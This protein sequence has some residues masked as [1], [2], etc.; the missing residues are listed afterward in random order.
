MNT[1]AEQFDMNRFIA[2]GFVLIALFAFLYYQYSGIFKHI[3][4]LETAFETA[5]TYLAIGVV[6]SAVAIYV[7]RRKKNALT[8]SF[9]AV[10]ALLVIGALISFYTS[11]LS[12][13]GAGGDVLDILDK[14]LPGSG[15]DAPAIFILIFIIY[16]GIFGLSWLISWW[17]LPVYRH[18]SQGKVMH[19]LLAVF[20]VMVVWPYLITLVSLSASF[21]EKTQSRIAETNISTITYNVSEN[22]DMFNVQYTGTDI[23]KRFDFYGGMAMYPDKQRSDMVGLSVI[24]KPEA[25][26]G[27]FFVYDTAADET[28]VQFRGDAGEILFKSG[29]VCASD[30]F[31]SPR[32]F[33]PDNTK[34]AS[35]LVKDRSCEDMLVYDAVTREAK[36]FSHDGRMLR[37][38]DNQHILLVNKHVWE[39]GSSRQ[40][41]GVYD[42]EERKVRPITSPHDRFKGADSYSR[43]IGGIGADMAEDRPWLAAANP[44]EQCEVLLLNPG[45]KE[46]I[47]L[48]GLP[49]N[50]ACDGVKWDNSD[51]SL[52]IHGQHDGRVY[53]LDFLP[54][55]DVFFD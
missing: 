36:E 54:S 32:T 3:V 34:Y 31:Q 22:E 43:V 27:E 9:V 49:F 44:V 21:L 42:T 29:D 47:V 17:L 52:L 25:V 30:D 55:A 19:S 5:A 48:N 28:I 38:L 7:R 18:L 13:V 11:I 51:N 26:T 35:K 15:W 6:L 16:F 14:F 4:G 40:S 2:F 53:R 37:W 12:K 33:S 39:T 46:Q 45:D 20:L 24:P 41:L 8:R 1:P 10:S 50:G 23:A